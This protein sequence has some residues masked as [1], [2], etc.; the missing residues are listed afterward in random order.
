MPITD[1]LTRDNGSDAEKKT[2]NPASTE[3]HFAP[4][5]ARYL[6]V[7]MSKQKL[8]IFCFP[9]SAQF[10]GSLI[11]RCFSHLVVDE[12]KIKGNFILLSKPAIDWHNSSAHSSGLKGAIEC[13]Q[14]AH[15]SQLKRKKICEEGEI[16]AK[17]LLLLRLPSTL[18]QKIEGNSTTDWNFG[19][20]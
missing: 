18:P 2:A 5:P 7:F 12:K 10:M 8:E 9:P 14:S 4:P 17:N 13:L 6:E 20:S 19:G 16:T 11:P 3:I 15:R 1:Y